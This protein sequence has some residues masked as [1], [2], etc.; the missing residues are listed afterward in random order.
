MENPNDVTRIDDDLLKKAKNAASQGI[1]PTTEFPLTLN[2]KIAAIYLIVIAVSGIVP[3]FFS[4]GP[5]YAEFEAKSLAYKLGAYFREATLDVIFLVSGLGILHRLSWA[6]KLGVVFLA[7]STIYS[8]NDFAWGFAHGLPTLCIRLISF[9]I[10][11]VWNAFWIYL[12]CRKS[13][14]PASDVLA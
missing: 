9:G 1:S 11:G 13:G 3:F 10:V 5:H 12:L 7:I 2:V 8:A 4:I 14:K 6:R